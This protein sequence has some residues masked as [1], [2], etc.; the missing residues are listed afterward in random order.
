MDERSR[1][2]NKIKKINSLRATYIKDFTGFEQR[3]E[4][5]E[6]AEKRYLRAKEKHEARLEKI[7]KQIR[8]LEARV[9]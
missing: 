5:G 8:D 9:D 1:I 7:K 4:K 3:Y 6:I 2:M